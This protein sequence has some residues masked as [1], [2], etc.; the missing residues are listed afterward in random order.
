MRIKLHC[1]TLV[2]GKAIYKN[3]YCFWFGQNGTPIKG[4]WNDKIFDFANFIF[5]QRSLQKKS[6]DD[7]TLE[8]GTVAGEIL[9]WK[10]GHVKWG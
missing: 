7:R 1:G 5:S 2:K 9:Q 6:I 10:V 4:R 8:C 3:H